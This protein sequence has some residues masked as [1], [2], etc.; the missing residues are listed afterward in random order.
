MANASTN[1]SD[2]AQ[3]RGLQQAAVQAVFVIT[4]FVPLLVFAQLEESIGYVTGKVVDAETGQA[5]AYP[6]PIYL[7]KCNNSVCTSVQIAGVDANGNFEFPPEPRFLAG[8][9]RVQIAI[10]SPANYYPVNTDQVDI[11]A[12][13]SF[14]FGVIRVNLAAAIG[15]IAGTLIRQDDSQALANLGQIILERCSD[16]TGC[17]DFATTTTD[18]VGRFIFASRAGL[19]VNYRYRVRI[20]PALV[21]FSDTSTEYFELDDNEHYDLEEI[22]V[23]VRIFPEI[24]AIRGRVVD[25]NTGIPPFWLLRNLPNSSAPSV[26]LFQCQPDCVRLPVAVGIDETGRFLIEPPDYFILKPGGYRVEIYG[27]AGYRKTFSEV[28][29]I[30]ADQDFDFGDIGLNPDPIFI[31]ENKAC[32]RSVFDRALSASRQAKNGYRPRNPCTYVHC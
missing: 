29:E 19:T 32:D 5:V 21:R 4:F 10:Q 27:V 30:S 6:A 15:S 11:G 23:P 20:E 24:S 25:A 31:A 16:E 9:Y 1:K 14:D 3:T 8:R 17:R 22:V 12:G 13:Q 2:S 7:Q 28:V 26:Q 18:D